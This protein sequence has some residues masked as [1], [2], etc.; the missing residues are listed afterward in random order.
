M[1]TSRDTSMLLQQ[2]CR[3][4]LAA[5]LHDLGKFAERSRVYAD[6]PRIDEQRQLVC[7]HQVNAKGGTFGHTHIHAAHTGIALD[8]L[9]KLRLL[10][11][12]VGQDMAPF[13]SWFTPGQTDDSLNNAAAMHH[14]PGTFLQWVVATADRVA[15]GF[16]RQDFDT[17]NRAEERQNHY[18][19]RLLTQFEQLDRGGKITP[20]VVYPLLP[21]S[22]ATLAP[23]PIK[24][25]SPTTN[26][27]G[28]TEYLALWTEFVG[29]LAKIPSHF[30]EDLPT[31][32][33][34]FDSA[35]LCYTH[36][37]ASATAGNTQ[38]DVSLYDH[39]KATAAFATA[40][41]RYHADNNHD[42]EVVRKNLETRNGEHGWQEAK[43]LLIQGDFFGIQNYVFG[44][45]S[46]TQKFAA[47]LLRGR[48]FSVAL[49]TELAA[50]KVLAALELPPTSQIVNAAGKFLIVAP[51]TA[52]AQTAIAQVRA[53]VAA[54]FARWTLG[55]QGIG[56]ATEVASLD[57]FKMTKFAAL[58]KRLAN[59]LEVQKLQRH[60]LCGANAAP[61]I[62]ADYLQR[63]GVAGVC[64]FDD[65]SPAET[66]IDDPDGRQFPASCLAAEQINL[67]RRLLSNGD[68]EIF[69]DAD[70]KAFNWLGYK[71][72]LRDDDDRPGVRPVRTWDFS[73]PNAETDC[74][75][76]GYA[77]RFV[78]TYVPITG[79]NPTDFSELAARSE[80]LEALGVLKGD[81]DNLGALF[82]KGL[83]EPTFA[84]WASLSRQ[85]HTFF[86]VRLPWLCQSDERFRNIYTVFAGGDDFFLIGPWNVVLDLGDVMQAEFAKHVAHN[87]KITFS[88]GFV[89]AQ[90]SQPVRR[91]AEAAEEALGL[92]KKH[93]DGQVKK[94][95]VH[96]FR[97]TVSWK[98]FARLRAAEQG[99]STFCAAHNP[100][101][102]YIYG[103]LQL[104][105]Q[106]QA[107]AEAKKS[108]KGKT[109]DWLWRARFAY[110]TRRVFRDSAAQI[111][112][113]DL[114]GS[115]L[116]DFNGDYRLALSAHLYRR[117]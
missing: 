110:R 60:D 58:R 39:S 87:A 80:G 69:L 4:A 104:A 38:P 43:I 50:L 75:F 41:W 2:S 107:T 101:N 117:R 37:I 76:A 113:N 12:M 36:A 85:L 47:K 33:D 63:C 44:S 115:A 83:K 102:G 94:N 25:T 106:A 42:L 40:I 82:E 23:R 53:E 17:Y 114:F 57:D 52:V 31:W 108:G 32:L 67:G 73:G 72:R 6:H 116:K 62:L 93:D 64:S 97:R 48:S 29:S 14:M 111:A 65:R 13:G 81:V 19:A 89:L 54:W 74:L 9:E 92:A 3:V 103:L 90:P 28:Q 55:Q 26:L 20:T 99:I 45:G 78:N 5:L 49:L 91:M 51:N 109:Q 86:A 61:A 70:S 15:S 98:T 59:A 24:E 27:Q 68:L 112:A 1:N 10:P 71:V 21:L 95:A 84:K 66:R 18:T 35:W 96:A 8:E 77:R 7:P 79:S 30:R 56:I 34:A 46:Q 105:D 16:E 100:S 88:T 22:P 11:P